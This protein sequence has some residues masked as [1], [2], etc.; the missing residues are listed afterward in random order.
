MS[1]L[2]I[3]PQGFFCMDVGLRDYKS[4]QQHD[5]WLSYLSCCGCTYLFI[6]ELG[7]NSNFHLENSELSF[8]RCLL[9]VIPM[10]FDT[11]LS[12]IP[13]I[14]PFCCTHTCMRDRQEEWAQM[15]KLI[16]FPPFSWSAIPSNDFNRKIS[17]Q[18]YSWISFLWTPVLI[19]PS[20][21]LAS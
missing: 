17:S 1:H 16:Y 15:D 14:H 18:I 5:L 11:I 2:W 10:G 20:N 7:Y 12:T 8:V 4:T 21:H 19:C 6:E 3:R 9:F 13:T